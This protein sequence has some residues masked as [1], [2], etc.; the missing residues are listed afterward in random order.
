[1]VNNLVFKD[2]IDLDLHYVNDAIKDLEVILVR[3]NIQTDDQFNQWLLDFQNIYGSKETNLRLYICNSIVYFIGLLFISKYILVETNVLTKKKTL[4]EELKDVEK[5]IESNFK[6]L[7]IIE[8][9]YFKPLFLISEREYLTLFT[10]LILE[11]T[12]SLFE[13]V[14][15][16]EHIFDFIT[17]NLIPPILK[18]SSGE[19]YT[20]PFLVKKMVNE[21]Y[22][23]GE[24]VLD[25]CCGSGNFI[26]GLI[27]YILSKNISKNDK[28][29]AI[30]RIYGFDINPISI[31][32][33]KI[34]FLFLLKEEI[35][36][37]K[38][39]LHVLDFLF[40]NRKD[41]KDKFDLIISNPPWYTYRDVDS[42]DYQEKLKILAENFEI[43]PRP[44]NILNLE[45]STL[46]FFKANYCY[47][48]NHAKIF[49]VITK[50]VIT[51]SHT[52]RFR[53]FKGFSDIRIWEFD[54]KVEKIFNIDFICLYGQKLQDREI[55]TTYEIPSYLF[56]LKND[57]VK[58]SYFSLIDLEL[59]KVKTLIPFSIEQKGE[60]IFVKKLIPKDKLAEL[61][62]MEESYYKTL[63]HKGADLNPRNLIFVK[64]TD[65]D[66][67]RA[68]INPDKRIFKRAKIPWNKTEYK[69]KIVEKKYLFQVLKSTELV[70]F[71]LYDHYNVFLPLNKE[72]LSFNY[73][74]L[75][76]D[77]KRFWKLINEIYINN[78]KATTAHNS[79]MEN[80]NRW[81]KL[82]NPRQLSKIKVVYNNSGSIL[83]SAVVEGDFLITGDLS[84]YDTDDHDEALYLSAILNSN[85]LTTQIKIMK[86][87]RHIFKL[88]FNIPIRKFDPKNL[89]H[90]KLVTLGKMGKE[91]AEKTISQAQ[92]INSNNLTK[93]KIQEILITK[94][95]PIFNQTDELLIRDIKNS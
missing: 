1:M 24:T 67:L 21:S 48:K 78:K 89:I 17:Q 56:A 61:L 27:K 15:E 6:D 22:S 26:V 71:H 13:S 16:P 91:I 81:A 23:L 45:I 55:W 70:K 66:D 76:K 87:S 88:P 79:L 44:K 49:F 51:G 12:C 30:N 28:I 90:Q 41:L 77:S 35:S 11:I 65:L 57:D 7:R 82:I 68:Q 94:L 31:F 39:N 93:V 4:M 73:D 14:L 8:L 3:N 64:F 59:K 20:P 46:F 25:P 75:D 47:L 2:K 63:F 50:G 83:N 10:T 5:R 32:T 18:H 19:Y 58:I 85:I 43:K 62:P 86:S 9:E 84:F 95:K 40:Q 60:K 33:A 42:I 74:R 53:N 34:N 29:E 38:L 69:D 72:D 37:I 52:S 36:S 80:L 54:K 92:K